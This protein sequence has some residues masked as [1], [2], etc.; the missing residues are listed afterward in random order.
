MDELKPNSRPVSWGAVLGGIALALFAGV[1]V[2]PMGMAGGGMLAHAVSSTGDFAVGVG[3]MAALLI[4]GCAYWLLWS[5][6]R[7]RSV[8]LATGMIV[9]GALMTLL[10]GGCGALL[11][12]LAAG[13]VH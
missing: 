7:H 1:L 11:S 8:D 9:G 10:S 5:I 12:G 3:A 13:G 4:A 6:A 2:V